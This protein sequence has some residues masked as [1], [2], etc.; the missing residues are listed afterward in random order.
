M[1]LCGLRRT[2]AFSFVNPSPLLSVWDGDV[3]VRL[4]I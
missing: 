1:G 2:L 4:V 3:I